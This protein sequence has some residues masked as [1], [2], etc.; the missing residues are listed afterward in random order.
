[1]KILSLYTSSPSTVSI[2]VDGKILAATHEERFTRK[3]NDEA[4]PL[5]SIKYCLDYCG[6]EPFE[7]DGV[8]LASNFMG[9]FDEILVRKSQWTVSDYL[10]EQRRRWLPSLLKNS[11]PESLL[12]IFPEKIDT[13]MYPEEFWINSQGDPERNNKFSSERELQVANFL[14]IPANKVKRIDHHRCHAAYSY[15]ASHFRNEKI[16]AFT[17]DGLGDGLNATV[18]IFDENGHYSRIYETNQCNIGRIYRYITLLL[19]MKPNEHEFKVMGLAPYGRKKHAQEAIDI[20]KSTLYVDGIN[21]KWNEKPTDSYYWFKDRLEGVRFDNIAFALQ[22]WT[23][24]LLTE[25]VANCIQH[26]GISKIVVAGGVAMNI[27]AMGKIAL[28]PEV[29]DIF[30]GGSA[31]DESMGI[32]A[33]ICLAED[34]AVANKVNWKSSN[35]FSL[36]QLYLGPEGSKDQEDSV[37]NA[38]D[39]AKFFYVNNPSSKM[40][41]ELLVEGKILA[42]CAGRMEFGQRSLGNRSILADPK[43]LRVREKINMAIKSRDFWMP[44]APIIMD[45]YQNQYLDNPKNLQSPHMTIG[46]NT[47]NEGYEAMLAACH[48]ADRSARPQ[49]LTRT[50]NPDL[51][52]ILEDF[53]SLTGRGALLNTS[54]NLH[55]YPIVNTPAEAYYVLE[56]SGLDGLIMNNYIILRKN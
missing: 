54:F 39:H 16:L 42:R 24:D 52:Q 48:P 25:W 22:A 18:G 19:G 2:F 33:G 26:F 8:A 53:E 49:I 51:Y 7:L 23:E 1:M 5:H 6:I 38:V 47:T 55:G 15:Y 14:Q 56:N 28:L 35:V 3:K 9:I 37:I 29:K 45:K 20:F 41:A 46:F 32:S 21:F 10:K 31:S 4:F 27:K 50:I 34:L 36:P 11:K 30:V 13:N 17:V 44:F 43:D 40:I 12:D